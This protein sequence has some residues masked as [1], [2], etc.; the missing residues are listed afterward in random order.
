MSYWK[1]SCVSAYITFATFRVQFIPL[2]HIYPEYS[3]Y[4]E[5]WN[6][7]T[8]FTYDAAETKTW[9]YT[10]H[11][12][13]LNTVAINLN[14]LYTYFLKQML[15][16]CCGTSTD[17]NRSFW[18]HTSIYPDIQYGLNGKV[19]IRMLITNVMKRITV[20]K[21]N[22]QH[23]WTVNKSSNLALHTITHEC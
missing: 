1:C 3:D 5:S 16:D 7:G 17:H 4:S 15:P 23:V 14:I 10:S 9:G 12:S 20:S 18:K 6:Y 2:L 22:L 8:A 13:H 19:M 21:R 11:I